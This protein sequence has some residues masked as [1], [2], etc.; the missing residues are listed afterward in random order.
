MGEF[1]VAL[2]ALRASA[3]RV[4]RCAQ[5]I[6]DID[7]PAIEPTAL[8]G[9]TITRAARS[10]RLSAQLTDAVAD[11]R[12]WAETARIAATSFEQAERRSVN[13]QPLR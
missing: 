10:D 12:T 1:S 3:D 2:D 13:A 8:V 7:W 4:E 5:L 6:A 11:V 9:A